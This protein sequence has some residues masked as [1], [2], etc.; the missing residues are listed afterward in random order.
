MILSDKQ[1]K[2]LITEQEMI[3]PF[4]ET[5]NTGISYGVSSYGFDAKLS[6]KMFF[7]DK[8]LN[9]HLIL[10]PKNI[11]E[12]DGFFHVLESNDF[13]IVPPY[14]FALGK[15]KEYFKIPSDVLA[16]C[17]GKSTYARCGLILNVT[18]LEPGWEGFVTLEFSNSTPFPIKL[19]VDEGVCQFVFF[20]GDEQCEVTY[21]DKLGKYMHQV[22]ITLPKNKL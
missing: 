7:F 9:E 8:E 14:S 11:K 16:L 1:I 19:Y 20:Q 6:N 2:K 3:S 4:E 5:I 13:F 21:K 22:D 12:K 18:P 17:I 10:D 15:T